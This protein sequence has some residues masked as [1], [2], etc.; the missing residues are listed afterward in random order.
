MKR[1]LNKILAFSFITISLFSAVTHIN[2]TVLDRLC[3][4]VG[5]NI[6]RPI[7]IRHRTGN[8]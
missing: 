6:L 5:L 7:Q 8:L 2:G 4:V 1:S 3:N